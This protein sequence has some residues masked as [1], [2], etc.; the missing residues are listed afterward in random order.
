MPDSGQREDA[1]RRWKSLT[2]HLPDWLVAEFGRLAA[3][4]DRSRIGLVRE[5]LEVAGLAYAQ[6]LARRRRSERDGATQ[7][8]GRQPNAA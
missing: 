8:R 2:L 5:S 6:A 3:D 1:V 4:L 7:T